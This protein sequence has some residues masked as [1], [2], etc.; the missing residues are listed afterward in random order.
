[1]RPAITD[2]IEKAPTRKAPG[3]DQVQSEMLKI[4]T[5]LNT[6]LF[7]EQW[8]ACGRY[9]TLPRP[10]LKALLVKLHKKGEQD[11]PGNYR[12]ISRLSHARKII[13]SGIDILF[14]NNALELGFQKGKSTERVILRAA[15]LQHRGQKCIS[16]LNLTAA[17]DTVPRKHLLSRMRASLPRGLCNMA[18][19]FFWFPHGSQK[20]ETNK[21]NGL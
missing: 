15:E 6:Q 9:G 5:E 20:S 7:H 16:V 17:Y 21:R 13:E 10:W 19:A 4:D 8:K 1:M 14:S 3:A 18:Q 12:P 2:A 11:N